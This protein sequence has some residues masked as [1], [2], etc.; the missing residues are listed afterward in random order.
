MKIAVLGSAPSSVLKAPFGDPGWEIWACSPGAYPHLSRISEFWEVHRWEPGVVGKPQTQKPWFTPEY[1]QWLRTVPPVVWVGDEEALKDLPNAKMLPVEQLLEK[2][3]HYIWT[4][5]IAYML[6]M[7]IEK[8]LAARATRAK[9]VVEQDVIGLWGVDMAANE[10]LYSGQRSACQF[11][12]QVLVGL[13]IEFFI[14]PESDLAV[15]PPM[16][17]I[18]ETNHR[19]I[20]WLERRRELE[21]RLAAVNVQVQSMHHQSLFLQGAIDDIDYMQKMWLHEGDSLSF[22]V[23]KL[24]PGIARDRQAQEAAAAPASPK[25]RKARAVAPVTASAVLGKAPSDAGRRSKKAAEPQLEPSTSGTSA[26]VP[27]GAIPKAGVSATSKS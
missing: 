5:S 22:D 10:E 24:F 2:Y 17:G 14:P 3:G 11:F 7:A 23:E 18:S 20:K 16:Y 12:L 8:I 25:T 15:P 27:T 6:A 21:A 26:E 13:K 1:V 19:A 9:G 4:S